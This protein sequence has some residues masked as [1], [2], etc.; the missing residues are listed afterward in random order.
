MPDLLTHQHQVTHNRTVAA[1]LEQAGVEHLDWVVT[2]L[3]YTAMH[4]MD[5]VLYAR[6]KLN[7]RNHQQR[8]AAIANTPELVPLYAD[9]RELE[10]QSRESRYECVQFSIK[11]VE[12]LKARLM[13]IEQ[14]VNTILQI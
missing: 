6:Q 8:H 5:Q 7:P 13:G 1:Y 12:S 3:F 11:E 9:Y 10:H 14:T 4:L 2:V